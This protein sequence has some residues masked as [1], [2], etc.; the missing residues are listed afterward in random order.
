MLVRM[1]IDKFG[2]A[3]VRNSWY[4]PKQVS[5]HVLSGYTK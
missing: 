2:T 5:E 3:A 1:A 4:D